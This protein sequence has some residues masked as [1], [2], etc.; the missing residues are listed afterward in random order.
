MKRKNIVLPFMVLLLTGCSTDFGMNH[1]MDRDINC[2]ETVADIQTENADEITESESVKEE[3]SLSVVQPS[4]QL[5]DIFYDGEIKSLQGAVAGREHIFL[6]GY[7][8]NGDHGIYIMKKGETT[9]AESQVKWDENN[10]RIRCMTT[11][12]SGNCYMLM[13]SVTEDSFD[14]KTMEIMIVATDGK[15]VGT[16][17]IS[18]QVKGPDWKI[19]PDGIG[20]DKE[21][22]IYIFSEAD[23]YSVTVVNADGEVLG[24]LE[25]NSEW[26]IEGIGRGK[27]GAVY[28]VYSN[29]G[30]YS[31]GKVETNGEVTSTYENVLP[32][33][34]GKYRYIFPGTDSNLLIY[35]KAG[36]YTYTDGTEAEER[37]AKED[38]S[39][40]IDA[41]VFGFLADGRLVVSYQDDEGIR[42]IL[43]VPT[44]K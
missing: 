9:A 5:E 41:K 11:D 10:K 15:V 36:I 18:D 28:I 33:A 31:I 7:T 1:E 2:E 6:Y 43:Y 19:V 21:G 25:R 34:F 42:H 12:E 20:V 23:K 32:E 4:D 37:I 14:Y 24:H 8:E 29:A 13:M 30:G 22:N 35:G 17:D 27:D 40:D 38:M 39:F 44:V 16:I 26:Y 3:G